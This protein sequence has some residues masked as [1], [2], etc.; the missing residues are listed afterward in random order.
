MR[1]ILRWLL[2]MAARFTRTLDLPGILAVSCDTSFYQWAY[3][4]WRD[5]GGV[6]QDSDDGDRFLAVA[7]GFGLG[8]PTGV[9]LPAEV[10]GHL[11]SREW[12]REYWETTREASCERAET[13]YP[14]VEDEERRAFLEQLARENCVDGWQW[15][16]GDAVNFS[17]GQ[18]DV[19]TTPLQ[20]ATVYA[21]I[22]NGG[23]LWAP[24]VAD[25]L[26]RRARALKGL[27]EED[28]S[29]EQAA[30]NM[31]A[32]REQQFDI[33]ADAVRRSLDMEK[34]YAILRGDAD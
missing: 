10:T 32:Y 16:P 4:A 33:L 24:R 9:D 19:A 6:G 26:V 8:R 20:V 7:R 21:A 11:P 5:Q 3:D 31:R 27:P 15:R 34:I 25:A 29:A 2:D 30:V 18:G 17:I 1:T 14:E 12:K 13:G 22:A 28:V 23:R